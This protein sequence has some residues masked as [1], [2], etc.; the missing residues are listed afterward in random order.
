[1]NVFGDMFSKSYRSY[2]D[3]KMRKLQEAWNEY[4]SDNYGM[5]IPPL[6]DI[7]IDLMAKVE[8]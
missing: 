2:E 7:F 5:T 1:M 6:I 4:I 8:K 3:P